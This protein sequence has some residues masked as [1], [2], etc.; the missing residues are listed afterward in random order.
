ML[1]ERYFENT[2]SKADIILRKTRKYGQPSISS[3]PPSAPSWTIDNSWLT[4]Q[5]ACVFIYNVCIVCY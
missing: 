4:V 5:G 3:P 1:D 2:R